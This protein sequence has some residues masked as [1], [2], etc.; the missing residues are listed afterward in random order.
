MIIQIISISI[1]HNDNTH[2]NNTNAHNTN[3]IP[4]IMAIILIA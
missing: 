4:E 1:K 2:D 3:K